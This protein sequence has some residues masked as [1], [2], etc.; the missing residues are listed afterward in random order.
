M[1]WYGVRRSDATGC[2]SITGFSAHPSGFRIL[3]Q[4][5]IGRSKRI[6]DTT[7]RKL[8]VGPDTKKLAGNLR[9]Y[10]F[11]RQTTARGTRLWR[12]KAPDKSLLFRRRGLQRGAGYYE[13]P[14]RKRARRECQCSSIALTED[15]FGVG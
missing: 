3:R 1:R 4:L 6:S 13:L 15:G 2:K 11:Q 10:E 5:R 7:L 14:F 8:A 9:T 12:G